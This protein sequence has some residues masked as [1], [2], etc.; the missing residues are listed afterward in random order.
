MSAEMFIVTC[1]LILFVSWIVM[2]S[3]VNT[4]FT[5]SEAHDIGEI[6]KFIFGVG[7]T[8]SMLFC[9]FINFISLLCIGMAFAEIWNR[10]S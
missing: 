10:L 6:A 1:L 3:L 2:Y 5:I 4:Y 8:I 7:M 9:G